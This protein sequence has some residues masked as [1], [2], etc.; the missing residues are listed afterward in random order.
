MS[1]DE[2]I[3]RLDQLE[4]RLSR[5]EERLDAGATEAA[6]PDGESSKKSIVHRLMTPEV[7]ATGTHESSQ[8]PAVSPPTVPSPLPLAPPGV[9]EVEA[10]LEPEPEIESASPGGESSPPYIV[11]AP[12]TVAAAQTTVAPR[13]PKPPKRTI[14]E[15]IGGKWMAWV[16]AIVIVIGGGFIVKLGY[17]A[18]WRGMI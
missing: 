11:E 6:A 4:A 17:D 13:A 18:G 14:E 9:V 16:G 12:P 1:F 7:P 10:E 2:L 5:I 15:V 3:R 8:D